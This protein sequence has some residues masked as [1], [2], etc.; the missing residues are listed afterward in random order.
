MNLRDRK[1]WT[2]TS[3]A[4]EEEIPCTRGTSSSRKGRTELSRHDCVPEGGMPNFSKQYL[5]SGEVLI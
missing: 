2:P 4:G 3:R 1:M 5:Y